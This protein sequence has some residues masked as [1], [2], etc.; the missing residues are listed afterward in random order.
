MSRGGP[1]PLA[2]RDPAIMLTARTIGRIDLIK[3]QPDGA[4]QKRV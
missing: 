4:S 1:C 2:G 3:K